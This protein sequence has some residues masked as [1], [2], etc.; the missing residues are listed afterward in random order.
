MSWENV[1]DWQENRYLLVFLR[2]YGVW[3]PD[4]FT[5]DFMKCCL[6]S[7]NVFDFLY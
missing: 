3:L 4:N 7:F 5:L 2:Q 6:L 1:I